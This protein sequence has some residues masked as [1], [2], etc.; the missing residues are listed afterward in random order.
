MELNEKTAKKLITQLRKVLKDIFEGKETLDIDEN[1]KKEFSEKMGVFVT[2]NR[3]EDHSLRGCIG[4][5]EPIYPLWQAVI[6]AGISSSFKDP[7]FYPLSR[8]ELDKVVI[9]LSFL[10]VPKKI[11]KSKNVLEQ[12]EIGKHGLIIEKEKKIGLLLPQVATDMCL[13]KEQFLEL[14]CQK[15]GLL[16]ECYK[17]KDTNIYIFEAL[18]FEEEYPNGP[19]IRKELKSCH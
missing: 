9:E 7:R 6:S 17:Q 10:S 13:T 4:I 16:K 2:L 1:I 18:V 3:Y 12:F 11:D 19:V 15:A 5:T 14:T 8:D